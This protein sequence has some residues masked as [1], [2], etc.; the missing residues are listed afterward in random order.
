[1]ST[2]SITKK[3]DEPLWV[4]AYRPKTLA[5]CILPEEMKKIFE[6]II[7]SG[8]IP[9]MLFHG[10]HGVGKTTVIRAICE[11]VGATYIFINGSLNGN[12]DTLRNEIQGFASR[13]SFDGSRKVVI[14]DEADYL[15]PQS[16]QPA[17][18]GFIEEF[19]KNC[20]F[21][22]T[23]N[24][25]NKIMAP[26][27]E[28]R[29]IPVEFKIS[30]KEKPALAS[31]MLK[32]STEILKLEGVEFDRSVVAEVVKNFFPDF[33]RII[34]QL[35]HYSKKSG[36]LIDVGMLS[37]TTDA[38]MAALFAALKAKKF[39]DVRKWVVDN[40][41]ADPSKIYRK[42]YDGIYHHLKPSHIPQI[43]ILLADYGHKSAFCPDQEINLLACLT[44]VMVESEWV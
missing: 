43:I 18:R 11:E 41:D 16:T 4:E 14:V 19:S 21:V 27:R 26:L 2:I 36:G 38:S 13:A 9:N 44:E 34:G 32:R 37:Q 35:Q 30:N 20:S 31:A 28:S 5:D 42:I 15:N 8:D 10:G 3:Q 29:L 33:R 6:G 1:M 39:A 7:K 22:F 12:I 23:C 17:L 24:N 25:K 40:I